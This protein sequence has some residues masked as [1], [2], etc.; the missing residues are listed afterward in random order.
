MCCGG[1]G[2]RLGSLLGGIMTAKII[3][4]T[5]VLF[6]PE[7]SWCGAGFSDL[8]DGPFKAHDEGIKELTA[9][10]LEALFLVHENQTPFELRKR[11][12]HSADSLRYLSQQNAP[13]VYYHNQVPPHFTEQAT[14]ST[15]ASLA[16]RSSIRQCINDFLLTHQITRE[17]L[18][19]H[20]RKTDFPLQLDETSILPV[21]A[22]NPAQKFFVCSDDAETEAKFRTFSNVI[23]FPKKNYV[24]KL[25]DGDW[26]AR[27]KDADGREF[28]FNVLRSR[29]SVIEGFCDM[30]I[31][32]RTRIVSQGPS[33]F[34]RFAQLFSTLPI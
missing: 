34:L 20:F 5:P 31:L 7:N 8:F 17:T 12:P 2:N 26:N 1:L 14:I 13:I 33:T 32:S 23:T 24:E 27:I 9:N 11:V 22:Q 21:I 15:L 28:K 25:T 3:G 19:I 4:R 6:W 10:N 18:G 16:V 30:L 29:E